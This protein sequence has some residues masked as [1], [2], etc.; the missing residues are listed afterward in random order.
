MTPFFGLQPGRGTSPVSSRIRARL[1]G[2]RPYIYRAAPG[3]LLLSRLLCERFS[4]EERAWRRHHP[5]PPPQPPIRT[6]TTQKHHLT[7]T[8][9]NPEK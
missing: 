6:T 4:L 9:A 8:T 2:N 1:D 5:R 7:T 3:A